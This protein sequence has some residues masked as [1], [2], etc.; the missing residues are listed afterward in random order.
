LRCL[1]LAPLLAVANAHFFYTMIDSAFSPQYLHDLL[2]ETSQDNSLMLLLVMAFATIIGLL[3]FLP[4]VLML[5]LRGLAKRAHSAHLGEHCLIVG[6][7]ASFT[8]LVITAAILPIQ[9]ILDERD[10]FWWSHLWFAPIL[11][12]WGSLFWVWAIYLMARFALAFHMARR[13]LRQTWRRDDR[14]ALARPG[15]RYGS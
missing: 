11:I 5:R 10:S 14:S 4:A 8:L 1:S 3:P 6:V 7:G 15:A 9:F 12:V 13:K 2:Y